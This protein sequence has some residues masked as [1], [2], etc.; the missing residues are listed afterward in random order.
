MSRYFD[1]R[2]FLAIMTI[3]LVAAGALCGTWISRL[4]VISSD[5]GQM[6]I[7]ADQLLNRA[8]EV[9]A[10]ADKMLAVVNASPH[11][12]C[13]DKEIMFLRDMLFGT[14]Y[15]KDMG[16]VRDGFFHCSAVFGNGKKP[17]P[18]IKHD[19]ETP[20]GKLIYANSRLAISKSTAPIIGI[21]NANVVLDPAAFETL[22]NPAYT[23]G[24][25]Y[26]PQGVS[27]TVGMFGTLDIGKTGMELPAGAG[28]IGDTVYRNVCRNTA[29]VTVHAEVGRLESSAEPITSI[30]TTFGAALGGAAAVILILLQRNNLSLKA[31][32]QH[33]LSQNRLT[34]EYQ[35][36]VDVATGRPVA[37]EALVRWRENGEWIPPDVFIPV[38][39]KAGLINRLTIC[40]IDHV[41]SDMAASLDANPDFHI[42]I[43]ISA[44]DLFD[45]HFGALLALRLKE[46]NVANNQIA[47]EIT[48]RSTANAADAKEAIERLRSRGHK[49]YIDDFGTGYSSL[50]YLGELN[51]DGIKIDKS[52]TQTIGTSSVSVSIVP[53]IIDMA[54][55]HGLAI[56]V[57]GI[58]TTA[59]RDYFAALKPKVDG[60]G[61]LFGRPA[62]A[63][64]IKK[65]LEPVA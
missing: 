48:E 36:I 25:M 33:A 6:Q 2:W 51:V 37:A 47:L 40:V 62:S 52:F 10:E 42:S 43:N 12:F 58:E 35:P 31:R 39:E 63:I 54:R 53:Q 45:R 19:L 24:V 3:V 34:V 15:L 4:V 18:L 32:L 61:W 16:R 46:A 21:G 7:F 1:R 56:V 26:N 9:F 41:L 57:E 22:K 38:A 11:P 50:A 23:F 64:T 28:R 60:Q 29:C 49:I 8:V 17:M 13:S 55:A 14:K 20:D 44:A 27:S 5:R 30:I 65:A 59:Q